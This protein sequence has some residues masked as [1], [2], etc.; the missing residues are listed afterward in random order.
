MNYT[1]ILENILSK[2]ISNLSSKIQKEN[3]LEII[4]NGI[5]TTLKYYLRFIDDYKKIIQTYTNNL[6]E[7]SKNSTE[8]KE[9]HILEW[10]NILK[11][12]KLK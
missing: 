3:D 7:D 4:A 10:Q 1:E 5:F 9:F 12:Y 2:A 11:E 8:I 6:I